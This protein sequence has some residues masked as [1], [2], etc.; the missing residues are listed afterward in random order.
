MRTVICMFNMLLIICFEFHRLTVLLRRIVCLGIQVGRSCRL[1][2]A[3]GNR[4][5]AHPF[6]TLF[7][8][9]QKKATEKKK[10]MQ[11]QRR[12]KMFSQGSYNWSPVICRGN[13][14]M[15]KLVQRVP[16]MSSV[17]SGTTLL[18]HHQM[19]RGHQGRRRRALQTTK[20]Y[21]RKRTSKSSVNHHL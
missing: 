2:L 16:E 15:N 13:Q 6:T 11:N 9:L 19:H 17:L 1:F 20:V 12:R 14:E 10:V 5:D 21:A 4:L 18:C 3:R 7:Y 8:C